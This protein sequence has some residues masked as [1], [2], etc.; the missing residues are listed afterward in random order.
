[1]DARRTRGAHRRRRR[2]AA[3]DRPLGHTSAGLAA[4]GHRDGIAWLRAHLLGDRRLV[5]DSPVRIRVTGE[6]SGGG[7]RELPAWPPPETSERPLWLGHAGRLDATAP[8]GVSAG[9][10]GYRYD[11]GDPTPAIG[12]P[13][14]L[15]RDPVLDNR[16]LE[17]RDDVLV[18]TGDPLDE[19]VE[20]I[21]D[22]RVELFI[23]ADSEFFD[24]FARVCDVDA[25]G[26]SWNVC[27]ALARVAP[28]RFERDGDGI[29]RVSFAL[30]PLGHRFAAGHR[31]RLQISSGAH[32]RY[33]RNPGTGEDPG[34]ATR[35]RPVTIEI[36]HG[37]RRPSAV[38][39]PAAA[40]RP[41]RDGSVD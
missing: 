2:D 33:A 24:V 18:Y 36:H 13:I 39:L 12:A 26:V 7:W 23:S 15:S 20:A 14:L 3:D 10:D 6:R 25:A 40:Q 17:A 5:S 16:E 35:M 28:E 21:G 34:T 27:D 1:M 11:P 22:V 41:G 30:W 37:E 19:I 9:A 8:F 32:P 38:I 29:W 4:A 31:I